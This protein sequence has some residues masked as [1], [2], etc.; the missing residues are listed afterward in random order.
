MSASLGAGTPPRAETTFEKTGETWPISSD[1]SAVSGMETT[2]ALG[3]ESCGAA[4]AKAWTTFSRADND[5]VGTADERRQPLP[6]AFLFSSCSPL[7]YAVFE[8]SKRLYLVA[9]DLSLPLPYES[10]KT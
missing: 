2:H 6:R 4:W 3:C 1:S 7:R 10:L 9:Y 5:R 8:M